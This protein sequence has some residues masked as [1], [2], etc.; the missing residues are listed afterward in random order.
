MKKYV[1]LLVVLALAGSTMMIGTNLLL[2]EETEPEPETYLINGVERMYPYVEP[3]VT[4]YWKTEGSQ[5]TPFG[6]RSGIYIEL[7][8]RDS[9]ILHADFWYR[10]YG[11]EDW[12]P[13]NNKTI[14]LSGTQEFLFSLDNKPSS[15]I[16]IQVKVAF[17]ENT[18]RDLLLCQK[19]A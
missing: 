11:A 8:C 16:S 19:V 13:L 10:I 14:E 7:E 1:I 4:C 9:N 3:Y 5:G 17:I 2:P 12:I 6:N 18:G 15:G